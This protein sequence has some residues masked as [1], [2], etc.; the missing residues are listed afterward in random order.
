MSAAR[1]TALSSRS[2]KDVGR[3]DE[4]RGEPLAMSDPPGACIE[5]GDEESGSYGHGLYG[6]TRYGRVDDHNTG[7]H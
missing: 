7:A 5:V 2:G 4:A 6:T 1:T 3:H